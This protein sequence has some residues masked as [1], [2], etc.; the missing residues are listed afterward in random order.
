MNLLLL[1]EGAYQVTARAPVWVLD[2]N[3]NS[4]SKIPTLLMRHKHISSATRHVWQTAAAITVIQQTRAQQ[5]LSSCMCGSALE[6]RDGEYGS[7]FTFL[8]KPDKSKQMGR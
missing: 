2:T 3:P 4:L 6:F 1:Y 8:Q 7:L 5:R